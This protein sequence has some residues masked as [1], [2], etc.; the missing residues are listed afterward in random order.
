M[1][2][3]L[4]LRGESRRMYDD[5][6]H[7]YGDNNREIVLVYGG[8]V[9]ATEVRPVRGRGADDSYKALVNRADVQAA[10]SMIDIV[11]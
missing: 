11:E 8:L 6:I 9:M 1:T 7:N 2:T 5:K 10:E 3:R 4:R